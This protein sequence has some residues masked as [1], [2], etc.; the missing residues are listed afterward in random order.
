MRD[1]LEIW[2]P[3]E[4]GLLARPEVVFGM[5]THAIMSESV[6]DSVKRRRVST[7]ELTGKCHHRQARHVLCFR[8]QA[9]KIMGLQTKDSV[10]ALST[11]TL[12]SETTQHTLQ[13]K[14]NV[15]SEKGQSTSLI[16]MIEGGGLK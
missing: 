3:L 10:S 12:A 16:L 8:Q 1:P 4:L 9:S 7:Q 5:A 2:G 13:K 15:L 6:K 11:A 14:T